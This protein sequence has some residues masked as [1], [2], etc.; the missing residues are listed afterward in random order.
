MKKK[1]KK[2]ITNAVDKIDCR[3]RLLCSKPTPEKRFAGIVLIIVVLAV[4]NIY[5]AVSSMYNMGR[6]DAK[7][8][9]FQMQHIHTLELESKK[10]SILSMTD[11][12][13]EINNSKK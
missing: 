13:L 12:T 1:I 5:V 8:Q 9:F 3:L 6:S 10:G 4:A 11:S 7:K 2:K